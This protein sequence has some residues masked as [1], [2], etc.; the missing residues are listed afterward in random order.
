MALIALQ[1][2][3]TE[4]SLDETAKL[5]RAASYAFLARR[6]SVA[7][8]QT[9]PVHA[10]SA[11]QAGR[12]VNAPTA[13]TSLY[14]GIG[15]GVGVLILLGIVV[16]TVQLIRKRVEH[17]RAMAA[18]EVEEAITVARAQEQDISEV[19]RPVSQARRGSLLPLHAKA[20]W[21]PLSSN[22]EVHL[23]EPVAQKDKRKRNSI[24]LP[25]RFKHRGIPLKRL[26]YLSA[27]MESPRSRMTKSPAPAVQEMVEPA[28][29]QSTA[30]E[31]STVRIVGQAVT[32][33]WP[34]N[35]GED[36][37]VC[38][39]SPKPHVIP[40]FAIRSPGQYS[41]TFTNAEVAK[42][43]RSRSMGAMLPHIPDDAIFGHTTRSNRPQLH[44][45]SVSL[46][47]HAMSRPPSGPVP[48]LPVIAPHRTN[49]ED[50]AR[51]GFCLSR[52][53]SS[54]QESTNSS[55]LVTSP[56]LGRNANSEVPNSPSLEE[57]IADDD[58]A[59]L[60]IGANKQW[61][62]PLIAGPRPKPGE[63]QKTGSD[64]SRSSICGNIA[65][66]S[67]ESQ[68]KQRLSTASTVSVASIDSRKNRLSIPQ[69]A[70][71]DRVSIS[72]VSS[73]NSMKDC[74]GVKKV[75]T[76]RKPSRGSTTVSVYGSPAERRKTSVL[77]DISGNAQPAP[78]RQASNATQDS[79]RSS[80]GNPFQW[81]NQ[82]ILQKP[83]ALKGSPN[84]RKG[85]RRQNCVRISTLTPQVLGPPPARPTS[86]SIMHGIEEESADGSD[87]GKSYGL[88]FVTNHRLSR[89]LSASTFAPNLRIQTLRASLT[90]SSPTLSAWTAYQESGLRS[91]PSDLALSASPDRG[92][93]SQRSSAFSIPSFPSP[94]KATVSTVQ[95]NQPVPEFCISRPSTDIAEEDSSSPF[96]LRLS[97]DFELPS[98]PSL[99]VSKNDE[100]DPA[101]PMLSIPAPEAKHEYDPASPALHYSTDPERSSPAFASTVTLS[102]DIS[103]R[104][105][106]TSYGGDLPDT[107]PCSPKTIPDGFQKFFD[108]GPKPPRAAE[109]LT[110]A[111]ASAV[112]ARMPSIDFPGAP[113][114][115]P[116]T[117][118]TQPVPIPQSAGRHRAYSS[119]HHFQ[120][121]RPAPPP[122]VPSTDNAVLSP[123]HFASKQT[124][125]QG[126]RTEPARSVLK[127]A[128]ALRRMNSEVDQNALDRNRESR[129]YA[130][131]GREASPLLPFIG[132]PAE[133]FES[134]N[135]LFD[136][137]FGGADAGA[138]AEV[139]VPGALDEVDMT[140]I[141]RRLEGALA[142][143]D[144]PAKSSESEKRSSSVWEDGEKF[145][146]HPTWEVTPSSP[147]PATKYEIDH[148]TLMAATPRMDATL[149]TPTNVSPRT[150]A[151]VDS[152]RLIAAT[153]RS[154]VQG[155]NGSSV[156]TPTVRATPRSLYDADGFL[157][158]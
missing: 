32:T 139:S 68:V 1:D 129:R 5:I 121:Q 135:D 101:W 142:G 136:F 34:V 109:K 154:I 114:L 153:P 146:E 64:A 12:L 67:A 31:H 36:V 47:A 44:A 94:S 117:D 53:S 13:N 119:I 120:P 17:R 134:C 143:F 30:N 59:Q 113:V 104:S 99:P 43:L 77:R 84:A 48:P 97:T 75:V 61:Q 82:G 20:G 124:S 95:R 100:Y 56:I 55:V 127:N 106:P 132:N 130:R 54:S 105:R 14:L 73:T 79:G 69:I 151:A 66:Y 155:A 158:T 39:E 80:N 45:R 70:T 131:L 26:K 33:D 16:V 21:G 85:H 60:R 37:F 35:K 110:S 125:P 11:V 115:L 19:P 92:T 111:N 128:M 23:P 138:G 86:P 87:S 4:G 71:A 123:L 49:S 25:K 3:G 8:A 118:Q 147:S 9:Q 38:P 28:D 103:P 91:N 88:P 46:G 156:Y 72:R 112:M 58:S 148:S 6:S 24:S 29:E 145:W 51:Q 57:V 62:N 96:A 83:S 150:S 126:P 2:G 140:D 27:I 74:A 10:E 133:A 18:L 63:S 157:R 22:E 122:P 50:P 76:P 137:D 41:A 52:M 98:S 102:D 78:S 89:P 93:T 40:S 81:D 65:R 116:T 144:A 90:P 7:Q 152:S 108:A 107:P 149:S 15:V 42:A 141:E